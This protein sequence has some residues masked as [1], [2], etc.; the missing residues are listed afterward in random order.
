MKTSE[1][2][3]NK[4]TRQCW[5]CLKRR[6]VC[7]HTLPLCRK[8][9]KAGRECS[10]YD[11]A[12]PLQWVE[13]GMVTSRRRKKD[14]SNPP[15]VVSKGLHTEAAEILRSKR[16]P[17]KRLERLLGFMYQHDLPPYD[18]S[19]ETCAV[20]QAVQ[21]Y[22]LRIH[23][24]YKASGE[25]A[26]NPAIVT[27]PLHTLYLLPPAI[28]HTVVC[29]SLNHYIHNLPLDANR[30]V[31]TTN[32]SKVYYHRGAAIQALSRYVGQEKTRCSDLT[33]ASIIIFMCLELQTPIFPDWRSHAKGLQRLL[34]LRGGVKKVT[35]E[36]P[37][38]TSSLVLY[39]LIVT[40][41][42]ACSPSWDQ[43]EIS[44][45]FDRTVD[46]V[47]ELYSLIFPYILCPL[48]LFSE[49]ICTN[50]L[51][52]KAS[53][54]LFPCDVDAAHTLEGFDVLAR[55]EAFSPGD[56]AQP[57]TSL[58]TFYDEWLLLGTIYQ[59]AVAIYTTMSLQSLVVLPS[60]LV[61]DAMRSAHG[62]GLLS[63]LGTALKYPRVAR[64]MLWPLVVAGVEAAYRGEA[65][66]NWIEAMLCDLSRLLGTSSPL[67]A[68]AV[69]RHYWLKGVPGWD[70]CFDR[71]QVFII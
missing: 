68:R 8:C 14:S 49:I 56:W 31:I 52:L 29:I 15:T 41:G 32:R 33:I 5:E 47:T 13:T 34:D 22:N 44:G 65:T 16:D 17:L 54:A 35:S 63:D 38:M 61:M 11:D 10:G 71:P 46:D 51:R 27:F 40:L 50:H 70:E 43:I 62:D 6:L 57:G 42:N 67:K 37:H 48:R 36:A 69:L 4:A 26:P 9:E 18:L 7:D 24:K 20:V 1:K 39:V 58:G 30:A 45:T 28:H 25:L 12:K 19:S 64:F 53:T 66:R 3:E 60:T 59:A 21:Y 23:P 55:I 2:G